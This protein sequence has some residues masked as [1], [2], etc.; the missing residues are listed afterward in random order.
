[1]PGTRLVCY[2]TTIAVEMSPCKAS[3]SGL[4]D[5][6]RRNHHEIVHP[7]PF[8]LSFKHGGRDGKTRVLLAGVAGVYGRGGEENSNCGRPKK[9]TG[10][11]RDKKTSFGFGSK[12][13]ERK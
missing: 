13:K 3:H 2:S 9:K 1:M 10:K 5:V 4:A 7:S 12:R 8:G 6:I 11:K